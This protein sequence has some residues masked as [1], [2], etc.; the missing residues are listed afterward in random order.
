MYSTQITPVL[1]TE[2]SFDFSNFEKHEKI[3]EGSF[4]KA[5]KIVNKETGLTY[6]AKESLR[7]F[8]E[9]DI[10][11]LKNLRREIFILSSILKFFNV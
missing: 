1:L 2:F 9:F 11:T 4:G 3:G 7:I 8:T 6:V 5:F 10:Y